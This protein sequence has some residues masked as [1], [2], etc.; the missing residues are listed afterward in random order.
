[1]T[2]GQFHSPG[3][4]E[5]APQILCGGAP[6]PNHHP[7]VPTITTNHTNTQHSISTHRDKGFSVERGA[8]MVDREEQYV[9][10]VQDKAVAARI[11]KQ[12]NQE[13]SKAKLDVRL[14]GSSPKPDYSLASVRL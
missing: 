2:H 6:Q 9:L 1:M 10:R 3:L 13:H 12:L 8:L 5:V 7:G 14:D 4:A 11:R